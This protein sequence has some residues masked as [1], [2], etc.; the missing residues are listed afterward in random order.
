MFEGKYWIEIKWKYNRIRVLFTKRY[1]STVSEDNSKS[2]FLYYIT[3]ERIAL[4]LK[5]IRRNY[6]KWRWKI[7]FYVLWQD[8][9]AE[10]Q[11]ITV[12]KV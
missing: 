9:R 2:E 3:E 12:L 11:A 1:P 8:I 10:A 6:K 4:K 5:C 7:T